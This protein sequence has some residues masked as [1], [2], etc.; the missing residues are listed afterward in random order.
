MSYKKHEQMQ[1]CCLFSKSFPLAKTQLIF[2]LTPVKK[3]TKL[4]GLFSS[5]AFTLGLTRGAAPEPE[6]GLDV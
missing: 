5:S 4:K 2:Q 3:S 1:H 6:L